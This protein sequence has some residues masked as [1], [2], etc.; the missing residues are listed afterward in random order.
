MRIAY[1]LIFLCGVGLLLSQLLV[2]PGPNFFQVALF[3]ICF[4]GLAIAFIITLIIGFS[5]WRKS[6][7]KWM[8]PS[9]LCVLFISSFLICVKIGIPS[10]IEM[11]KFQKHI[12]D[13]EKIINGIQNGDIQCGSKL[14]VIDTTNLPPGIINIT[15][16]H[17]SDGSLI[18]LFLGKGSSFAGHTGY[19]F[20]NYT[21]TNNCI[22][23]PDWRFK[24]LTGNWYKF[25]D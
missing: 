1:K 24:H 16:A 12:S 11:W 8:F 19:L 23:E 10:E 5:S 3:S 20:K 9:L 21:K 6:S 17:C 7:S 15:A 2:T 14:M 13:Y 18:V 25:F 22:S 4:L